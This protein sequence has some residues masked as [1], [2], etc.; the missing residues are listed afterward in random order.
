MTERTMREATGAAA[1]PPPV[2]LEVVS[3]MASAGWRPACKPRGGGL[4][5]LIDWVPSWDTP[6]VTVQLRGTGAVLERVFCG[7]YVSRDDRQKTRTWDVAATA[8]NVEALRREGLMTDELEATLAQFREK[9][10]DDATQ[11][12]AALVGDERKRH[13]L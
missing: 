11:C 13:G 6:E 10:L 12:Y 5:P 2:A 1:S 8:D 4:D 9:R 3:V 7:I